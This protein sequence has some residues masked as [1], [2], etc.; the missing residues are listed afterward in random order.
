MMK[1]ENVQA[2]TSEPQLSEKLHKISRAIR[3]YEI[4][5]YILKILHDGEKKLEEFESELRR[6]KQIDLNRVSKLHKFFIEEDT[7][8]D[9][10]FIPKSKPKWK[11][12]RPLNLIAGKK[13]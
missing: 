3:N 10:D 6:L 7:T 9:K 1:K 4:P 2:I 13:S 11:A 5:E 8:T 12:V